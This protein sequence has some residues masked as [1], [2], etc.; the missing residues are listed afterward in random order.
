MKST[1]SIIGCGWLGLPLAKHFI[2]NQYTVKGS[3]TSNSKLIA[4]QS[5]GI[6]PFYVQLKE[7]GIEGD[8][9]NFLADTDT[10]IVNIPPGLRN[11][12]N[13]NHVIE[14]KHLLNAIKKTSVK[15]ILYI[16]STSVFKDDYP[17]HKITKQ[18]KPNATSEAGKQLIAIEELIQNETNINF[19][20]LRFSGLFDSN[21]HPGKFLSGKTSI[22]NP[23][24]PVNLVHKSDCIAII[25]KILEAKLCN[26]ILNAC[27]PFHPTK[28]DYYTKYCI[29]Q[30]LDE[31]TYDFNTISKGKQID[32]SALETILN[33]TYQQHP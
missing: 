9:S 16:S 8:I 7:T 27:Y 18:T 1:L 30:Q 17:F 23:N 25:F 33:Y 4:L 28:K 6:T 32:G 22:K 19:N 31:P 20:I 11:N 2:K 29:Q 12:P 21:R 5:A 26:S 24:A 15:N 14:I 10:L 3:T 13:K